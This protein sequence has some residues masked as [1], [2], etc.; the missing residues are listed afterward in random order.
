MTFRLIREP[1]T[2]G[3]TLGVLFCDGAFFSFTL[4][5]EIRERAGE[6]VAAWKV[7]GRTAIPAGRYQV[8]AT[9]SPKFDR[10]LPLLVDVPGFE[11]IRVHRGNRPA[12]TEGCLLVG[13][14][15]AQAAVRESTPAEIEIVRRV[16]REEDAGRQVWIDIENPR[17]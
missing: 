9:W 4:E 5:D 8:R 2:G 7:P 14:Q 12:D 6:P 16:E 1:S 13:F 11:G 10:V 15:R 3:A 17:V